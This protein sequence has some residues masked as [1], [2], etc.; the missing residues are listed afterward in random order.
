MSVRFKLVLALSSALIPAA[1]LAA[2]AAQAQDKKVLRIFVGGQQRPDVWEQ[3]IKKYEAA[4]PNFDVEIEVG[5][6]TSEAQQQY[7]TTVL[8]SK[9]DS[10][11]L[12][13]IDI[14]R[15]AQYAAAGWA[16]PLDQYL[17]AGEKDKLLKNYLPAYAEANQ[18]DGKL[19]SMPSFADA[20]F[21]Y[22]RKDLFEKHGLTPPKTWEEMVAAAKKITAA[23]GDP[24]L[25]GISF[26]GAPIE[27][28]VCTFLVPFWAMGGSLTDGKGAVTVD[29]P[30]ARKALDVWTQLKTDKLAKAS[31]AE[32]KTD[33]I[34]REFQAGNAAMAVLWAYGW[35]RFQNDAD[36]KVK[37]KVGVVEL[38][39]IDGKS[40]TCLGG[41][42]WAM[43]A[44]SSDKKAAFDLLRYLSGP[45]ASKTLALAASNLP[46]LPTVYEDADVLKAN[47]WFKDALPVVMTARAR[48]VSPR[49]AEVSDIIRSNVNA[50]LAGT[51]TS[52]QAVTEMQARLSRSMR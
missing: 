38:P 47:P 42:Q 14:V 27:G 17:D 32:V 36:S 39:K 26:T 34:R 48:P 24:N 6:A 9:D 20:Q 10:I 45:E 43:S 22:Y 46:V 25:Q 21:L 15:P 44:H 19:Y 52:D 5:G 40:A 23:E 37:D 31:I 3:V 51:K 33:D 13:L 49:Y 11:D 30:Q 1:M 12:M 16:E 28:A 4:N 2:P 7:L 41:W 18:V 35:N 8:T 50:V 29:T